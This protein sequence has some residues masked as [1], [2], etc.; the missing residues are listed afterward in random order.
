MTV[1]PTDTEDP[2]KPGN[3]SAQAGA[4]QIDLEWDAATD[5][6]AVTGYEIRR[7]GDLVATVGTVT[8]WSDLNVAAAQAY[9]YEVRALDAAGNV[10]EPSDTASATVLDTTK[11]SI[12]GNLAATAT[13][14]QVDL[15]W[16][17]ASD[18]VAVTGY[19]VYRDGAEI[20]TLGAVT[21]YSDTS[22]TAPGYDYVVRAFDAADNFSDPSNTATATVPDT[23]KPTQ[24]GGLAATAA[25][26]NQV[27]L[28]WQASSDNIGVTGYE[29]YRDSALVGTAG[30]VTSYADNGVAGSTTYSYTVRAVDAAENFSD[31]SDAAGVTTPVASATFTFA[32]EADARTQA[33]PATTNYATSF[34]RTDGSAS[35]PTVESLLRFTVTGAPV[36]SVRSAKLRVYA[37]SG[38]VDG[39]AVFTTNPAWNETAV[40]WNNR[41]PRTSALTQDKGAIATNSWVEYDVLQFVTG[42]GTYSF[43]L[44]GTSTDGTDIYSRE[45]ATLRPEL[46][47]TTGTPDTQKPSIPANLSANVASANRV[48][49]SWQ[50]SSDN[51]G[52]TGYTVYRNGAAIATLGTTTAYSDTSVAP[53]STYQYDV[54]AMDGAGNLSDPSTSVSVTTPHA[55]TVLTLA[56]EADTRVHE[57]SPTTNYATS[58]LRANGGTESDVETFLRFTVTGAPPGSV[59]SAKLRLYNYNG[60]ADGPAIYTTSTSWAET[61]VTWNARPARTSGATD[62]KGAIP[63]NTW[64]EYDVTPFVT[65][66]GTY[67]FTLATTSND[68]IDFYNREAATLRPELVL[69]IP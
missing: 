32:P 66:N 52:V 51:V 9:E 12:P 35:A 55:A 58:Y 13:S 14:T 29:I 4:A 46:V 68:G 39:P 18:N 56:P 3:L 45:A 44:A 43:G 30:P 31:L 49:L 57:A 21:S 65:G 17:A 67:S 34:L 10:S 41:P 7:D 38:T 47:V 20:A 69:T 54:R 50:Q 22:V 62:D 6:R 25:G 60:T 48:D 5:N 42:N 53:D 19:R 40:N 15:T 64:V 61:G 33:S 8:S 59:Q 36:G 11:P 1:L 27:N 24:P 37:Y 26:P 63:V 16:D 23:Q 2:S 28:T